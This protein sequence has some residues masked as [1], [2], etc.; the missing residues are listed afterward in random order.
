[1]RDLATSDPDSVSSVYHDTAARRSV[2]KHAALKQ[3]TAESDT[4]NRAWNPL[5]PFVHVLRP[6]RP[7][8]A[9]TRHRCDVKKLQVPTPKKKLRYYR[10]I[11]NIPINART[12]SH[13]AS[14]DRRRPHWSFS[15]ACRVD[16]ASCIRYN[17]IITESSVSARDRSS[18]PPRP[19]SLGGPRDAR[20]RTG[21]ERSFL[22]TSISLDVIPMRT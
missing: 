9:R 11:D 20:M 21:L 14:F 12:L 18:I 5:H 4:E 22:L 1:M 3:H 13:G 10:T 6:P 17:D 15:P 2:I 8:G 16:Q 19:T 7:G